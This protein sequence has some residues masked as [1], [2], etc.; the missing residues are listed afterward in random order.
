MIFSGGFKQINSTL[1]KIR[2]QT[3]QT[4]GTSKDC[5]SKSRWPKSRWSPNYFKN[6]S[7]ST[8]EYWKHWRG[9]V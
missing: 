7:Q 9:S 6:P 4:L 3:D 8:I 2:I 1:M 5:L